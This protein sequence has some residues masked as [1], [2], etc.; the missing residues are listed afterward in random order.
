[1][2]LAVAREVARWAT[3]RTVAVRATRPRVVKDSRG[4]G[5][6]AG[7]VGAAT[8]SGPGGA[9]MGW[10]GRA[11]RRRS[12]GVHVRDAEVGTVGR[13]SHH[14][15]RAA[16]LVWRAHVAPVRIAALGQELAVRLHDMP[17]GVAVW[18]V[19]VWAGWNLAGGTEHAV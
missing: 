14:V 15:A 9:A 2:P 3:R 18:L 7:L 10:G 5:S 13:I 1:M 17:R 8:G 12:V 16:D 19:D 6:A 11:R 4:A